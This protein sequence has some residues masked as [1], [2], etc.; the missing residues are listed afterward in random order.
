MSVIL[1]VVGLILFIGLVVVHE[2]GHFIAAR[3]GGVGIEEFAIFFPPRI[4][5]RTTKAG[6]LF[7]INALPLGGYVRMKGEH[8]S[9]TEPGTFGAASLA[10]KSKIMIAGVVM[11]LL[12]AL[13]LFTL[14][15]LVGMPK[16]INNQ[17]SVKGNT[18][19]R[20]I[21]TNPANAILSVIPGSA[22]QKAGLKVGDQL[23][24]F[25]LAGHIQKITNPENLPALTKQDAGKMVGLSI[26]RGKQHL[27]LTTTLATAQQVASHQQKGYLGVAT[28]AE[29]GQLTVL[30]STW[31]A[32]IV[33]VGFTKQVTV[34]TFE[35]LG[36]AIG[37]L[38]SYFSGLT[39]HNRV[40]RK[41]G[42][43]Q[44]TN[45][46]GGPIAIVILLREGSAIGW[47]CMVEII[48]IIS[49]TLAIMN[50]LPIPA[51]D[52]GRFWIT[53][54]THA[55]H[56]PLSARREE[57]INASGFVFLLLLIMLVTIN[58]LLRHT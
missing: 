51:L 3:R 55:I 17:F 28:N 48:A 34:L 7:A 25:G 53:L 12:V 5:K 26:I 21:I 38:G 42:L 32:P 15:S 27:T 6:W 13:V 54:F 8:D 35:G 33:A 45:E 50:V 52:G 36:K 47:T 22:A 9:D 1:L 39:T 57:L 56:R 58:D 49:L 29:G 41:H 24:G 14:L 2:F 16:L 18:Q 20:T 44:A 11:N 19:T 30:R 4:Y 31:A 40:A 23:V 37:G 43:S 10:T 46:V